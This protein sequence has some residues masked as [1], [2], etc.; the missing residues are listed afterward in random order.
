[1]E[2]TNLIFD[3]FDSP[4]NFNALLLGQSGSGKSFLMGLLSSNYFKKGYDIILFDSGYSHI[5]L[6]KI[7]GK[8]IDFKL[9]NPI[10]V[11][12][13]ILIKNKYDLDEHL[14][15]LRH[16]ICGIAN[17]DR[18]NEK[19]QFYAINIEQAIIDLW[20]IH[21]DKLELSHFVDKF[22]Y[23]N[24]IDISNVIKAFNE[25]YGD[26]FK[27]EPEIDF[28]DVCTVIE[29]SNL[30]DT[31]ILRDA[32]ISALYIRIFNKISR[33]NSKRTV[34]FM[35]EYQKYLNSNSI[36][37]T[38]ESAYRKFRRYNASIIVSIQ[39]FND[40]FI[41]DRLNRHGL[42]TL[43]NSAWKIF[44]KQSDESWSCIHKF[45]KI[46]ADLNRIGMYSSVLHFEYGK[47]SEAVVYSP[48]KDEHSVFPT[49][50][51]ILE[52]K[53]DDKFDYYILSSSVSDNAEINKY[54]PEG[55]NIK[56][57]EGTD[58]INAINKAVDKKNISRGNM[59]NV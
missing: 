57:A 15:S 9:D 4:S 25:N 6:G 47:Y 54:L 26:F 40:I 37:T 46:S 23:S 45:F 56:N 42:I 20:N 34:C 55:M 2:L 24:L 29:T 22:Y 52:I 19:Y 1:M 44:L 17:I 50:I 18:N 59:V 36:L 43:N 12:P 32:V 3:V 28:N 7:L 33:K 30:D 35:D 48:F 49:D 53:P 8:H 51:K 14:D 13:F 27:Y 31:P 11:N 10:S 39:G 16:F 21:K 58:I 38:I 5:K 41:N